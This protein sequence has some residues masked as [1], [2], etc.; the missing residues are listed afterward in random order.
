MNLLKKLCSNTANDQEINNEAAGP[1]LVAA[2]VLSFH[3]L[4]YVGGG[5]VCSTVG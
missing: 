5:Q 1:A 4:S 3:E 2:E